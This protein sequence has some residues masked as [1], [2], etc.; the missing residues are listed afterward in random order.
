MPL[1]LGAILLAIVINLKLVT[2][3]PKLKGTIVNLFKKTENDFSLAVNSTESLL[4][5]FYFMLQVN[6]NDVS[7]M[8]I[9]IR[10]VWVGI[11]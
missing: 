4:Q 10:L 9:L 5:L 8:Y 2:I 3:D 7:L 1:P 6:K 11:R